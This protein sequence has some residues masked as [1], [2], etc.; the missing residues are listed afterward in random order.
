[1]KNLRRRKGILIISLFFFILLISI[2][3]LFFKDSISNGIKYGRWFTLDTFE[4]LLG[5][6]DWERHGKELKVKCN[7]LIPAATD[8]EKDIENKQYNFRI[9][10]KIDNDKQ[11]RI[12]SL[13]EKG[14]NVKW[15][16]VNEWFE[17]R[18][19]M[20]P[21]KFSLAYSSTDYLNFKYSGLEIRNATPTELYEEFYK[22]INLKKSLISLTSKYFSIEEYNNYV[23]AEEDTFGIKQIGH[24]YFMD[25]TLIDKYAE[26]NTLYLTFD[27][28]IN[29]KN[30]K[31]KTHTKSL[32]LI[33]SNDFESISKRISP[34]DI[35]SLI[36]G[37][38][39]QFRFFY[40]NE[41]LEN[42][43]EEIRM[44]C[45]NRDI[46]ITSQALC[47]NK[48]EILDPKFNATN[49]DIIIEEILRDPLEN[50][51]ELNDTILFILNHIHEFSK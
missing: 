50:F 4:D 36:I 27:T 14:S 29:D 33:D 46:H 11:L 18:G 49:K 22:N 5:D 24:I 19:K 25:G 23:F 28:R 34:N 48:G 2:T 20:F 35:D 45:I 21:I 32:M 41:K 7:A 47:D 31:I 30:I 10:S 15:D 6:C 3:L 40:I 16:G 9:I 12:F 44:Y 17:A 13:S 51:V 1:M 8:T 42:L 38:H 26:E 39:Y 37:D 43:L